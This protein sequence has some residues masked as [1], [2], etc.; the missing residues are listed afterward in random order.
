M[1]IHQMR[2]PSVGVVL[3]AAKIRLFMRRTTVER[4]TSCGLRGPARPRQT[5]QSGPL[6]P[7]R[8]ARRLLRADL[9]QVAR[10]SGEARQALGQ[11]LSISIRAERG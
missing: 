6:P 7:S 5:Q 9:T 10:D 1:E 4:L 3:S 11:E 2:A 8:H